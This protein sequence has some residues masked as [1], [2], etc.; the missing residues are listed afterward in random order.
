MRHGDLGP[1]LAPPTRF[2]W[3]APGGSG[4]Q[5]RAE[6]PSEIGTDRTSTR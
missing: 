3:T 2:R 1:T 4:E 6:S 5:A